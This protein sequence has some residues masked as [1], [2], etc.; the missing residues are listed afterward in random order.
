[1]SE[2]D[3]VLV[4]RDGPITIVSINRPHC[5]NAVDGATARKLYDA[6][7]A[8][9][10]D[11][12]ASVAVFTGTGGYF[13]AG[14]DLKAVASGDPNKKREIGGHD[15]IAPMGPSRLRLSK[16]VIAAVE[17]FAVAG[18]MELALWADMRV[19][20][21]DATFGIFCRR[22][23]VPLIDLGTIRLPRLIGHS[24]AIDLILS[25]DARSARR[26]RYAWA[27]PIASSAEARPARMRSRWPGKSRPSRKTA[28][29][30]T[31]CRRCG[32]GTSRKRTPSPTKCA[33]G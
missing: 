20:A 29:A 9:D 5:R 21:E 10:A 6:F 32:N 12:T 33:A 2:A 3:T 1:M 13:C 28:C 23:G 24:Q 16:P 4:E 26:K 18:G 31:A 8:F 19:V 11:A 27:L 7:L 15:S 22:F 25:P 14:A 17:G 30:P